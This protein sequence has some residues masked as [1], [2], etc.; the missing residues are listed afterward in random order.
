LAEQLAVKIFVPLIALSTGR[1]LTALNLP[2]IFRMPPDG[3]SEQAVRWPAPSSSP[4]EGCGSRK[5]GYTGTAA[6]GYPQ[7]RLAGAGAGL[8]VET[9]GGRIRA[10]IVG[11]PVA[12][13]VLLAHRLTAT[14]PRAGD[15]ATQNAAGSP[16]L[17]GR[18]PMRRRKNWPCEKR[19]GVGLER[20]MTSTPSR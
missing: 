1:S 16:R 9:E 19:R 18:Q 20:G 5:A 15:G 8:A 10:E 2:W 3:S 17:P 12:P 14:G 4:R 7:L 13:A 6:R 11:Q